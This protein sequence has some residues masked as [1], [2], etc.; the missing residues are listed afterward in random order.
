MQHILEALEEAGLE[1][2]KLQKYLP[3]FLQNLREDLEKELKS[4]QE[5]HSDQPANQ[6]QTAG[7]HKCHLGLCLSDRE[8]D[9]DSSF[10]RRL[11]GCG[12]E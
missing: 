8:S 12:E 4:E 5:P 10:S 7:E 11:A 2:R 9:V 6:V 3:K 1:S